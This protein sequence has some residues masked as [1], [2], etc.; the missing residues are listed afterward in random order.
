MAVGETREIYMHPWMAYPCDP[1]SIS[2]CRH[3][4]ALVT[5][6][7]AYNESPLPEMKSINLDFLLDP[8]ILKQRQENYKN[9]LRF[10][11]AAIAGHFKKSSEINLSKINDHLL[12]FQR[13]SEL[14]IIMIETTEYERDLINHLNWNIYF[15]SEGVRHNLQTYLDIPK[16]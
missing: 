12:A 1:Q 10:K 14:G 4:K 15:N 16:K 2:E 13:D 9:V 3:L 7:D 6:N 11:G 8:K 5:L